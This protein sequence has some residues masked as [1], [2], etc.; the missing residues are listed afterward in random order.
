MLSILCIAALAFATVSGLPDQRIIGGA[1]TT[2][3]RFPYAVVILSSTDGTQFT[4]ACGGTIINNR[5]ILSSAECYH[6][7]TRTWRARAG[8][9][10]ANSGG[11]VHN[12]GQIFIN[13]SYDIIGGDGDLAVLHVTSAF[14]Y[15]N[16]VQ[17]ARVGGANYNLGNGVS[18]TTVGWGQTTYG[19]QK[20]EQLRSV[21]IWTVN[22]ETC[23][24]NYNIISIT[25]TPNMMCAG[26][27][28]VGGRDICPGDYGGP[29]LHDTDVIVGVASFGTGCGYANYP[30]IYSRVAPYSN[31]I[32][33]TA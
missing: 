10:Y 2:I 26:H 28:G 33:S 14:S 7:L 6:G 30:G 15:G 18:V 32:V 21:E 17:P 31:W 1:L 29:L 22:Q 8:S 25:V 24:Q 5:A 12:I 16:N 20:S 23:R 19:G 13:P 11:S 27:L 9:S 3:D 4:Q